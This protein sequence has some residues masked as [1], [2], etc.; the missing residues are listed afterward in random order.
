[1]NN[2]IALVADRA[3]RYAHVWGSAPNW[4]QFSNQLEDS[5]CEVIENQTYDWEGCNT[6]EIAED[7][8]TVH[9]LLNDTTFMPHE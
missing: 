2:Y 6:E 3:G 5:G 7:C 8:L 1:M 9:Q 4:N